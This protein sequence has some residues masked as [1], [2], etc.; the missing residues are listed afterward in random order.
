VTEIQ[1]PPGTNMQEELASLRRTLNVI[2]KINPTNLL[3]L[4]VYAN[5]GGD[6]DFEKLQG[7][8]ITATVKP[9]QE[10]VRI[11]KEEYEGPE[12]GVAETRRDL[13]GI[14]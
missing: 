13:G 1:Y 2:G 11:S 14:F 4:I 7:M 6:V 3:Q 8:G 5:L 10:E 9:C 12:Q